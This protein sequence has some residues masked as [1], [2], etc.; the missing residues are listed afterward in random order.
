MV[1]FCKPDHICACVFIY[2]VKQIMGFNAEDMIGQE[3]LHF[4]HPSDMNNDEM[5]EARKQC[6]CFFSI[7]Q[8]VN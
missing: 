7:E 1:D 4:M 5:S 3:I 6:N 2:R 8:F